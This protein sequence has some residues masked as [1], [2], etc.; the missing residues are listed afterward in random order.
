MK[1]ELEIKKI[2]TSPSTNA[3]MLIL[4]QNYPECNPSPQTKKKKESKKRK[5]EKHEYV[6][7]DKVSSQSYHKSMH[8]YLSI[9]GFMIH[10]NGGF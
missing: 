8:S 9:S 7:I 5:R 6:N 4:S 2:T 3:T 1:G 10:D